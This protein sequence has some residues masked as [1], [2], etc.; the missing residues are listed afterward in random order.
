MTISDLPL[1][2]DLLKS[3]NIYFQTTIQFA[4]NESPFLDQVLGYHL[5]WY[6]Q[7]GKP[8]QYN[9]GKQIRP[10]L[11]LLSCGAYGGNTD[12]VLSMASAIELLHNFS[13]I[14]DDI[15][16]DSHQRRGRDSVWRIWGQSQ[17]I[18]AGDGAYGLSFQLM[19]EADINPQTIVYAQRLL[20]KACVDTVYGQMLDISFEDREFV[21]SDE[22][23]QMTSLKTGPLLGAALGGGALF[24]GASWQIAQELDV[25]GRN[26]GVAFQIQDDI[27]GIWGKTE[28]TG[29]STD[30]DLTAK[31]K[32]F[33]IIWALENLPETASKEIQL[34]YQNEAPLSPEITSKIRAI[35]DNDGVEE[36]ISAN[37][38]GRYDQLVNDLERY[39]PNP[40]AYRSELFNIVAFIVNRPF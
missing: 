27:L 21:T 14:H 23:V 29:K 8:T 31:K 18:N 20:S 4:L 11:N 12:D 17:A 24:A 3:F 28:Q 19:A 30:D 35:L 33:P 16:D 5:G 36:A 32:S 34:L 40:S 13:L 7:N 38:Q 25:I 6:D 37:V 15:M 10:L 22:Y 2:F 39:Y 9:R 26:L 1:S